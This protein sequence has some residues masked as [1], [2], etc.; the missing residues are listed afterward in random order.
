MIGSGALVD[1]V[2]CSGDL[3]AL[4]PL[5]ALV[6]VTMTAL[7][8]GPLTTDSMAGKWSIPGRTGTR[9]LLSLSLRGLVS[10]DEGL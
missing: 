3:V 9:R 2:L 1:L 7:L 8:G 6:A 4:A 10:E 5:L